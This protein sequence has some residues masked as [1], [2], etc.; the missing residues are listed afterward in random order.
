MMVTFVSQ[1]EKKALNKTRRVLDSFASRI[2]ENTWQ[3]IITHE[4]LNAVKKLLKKTASKNTAVSCHWLR[5]RSRSELIWIIGNRSKFNAQGIVP[6]HFTRKDI[7]NTRWENDWHYLPLIKCLAALASLFHDFGKASRYFQ[8]KLKPESKNKLGDPLRHEWVSVL[9][10]QAFVKNNS[11]VKNNS[12]AQWLDRLIHGDLNEM[13]LAQN[14]SET[15]L[16]NLPP[17]AG[18]L[19]WLIVSHHKLPINLNRNY[20]DD[21]LRTLDEALGQISQTWGYENRKD[22]KFYKAKL[23]QCL[24]FDDGLSSQSLP[25]LK[26]VKRWASKM[27]DCLF[28]LNK[29]MENGSWRL[30]LYHARLSLMLGDHNYS[31]Q[32]ASKT[33]HSDMDLIANTYRKDCNGHSKG[34]PNQKLDEHLVGVAHSALDIAQLLPAFENELPYAYDIRALKKKSPSAFGWQDKAVEKVKEWKQSVPVAYQDKQHGFFAVNMASTGCGKT[35]A[36]AKVMRALS[37]DCESLRFILALGLRTLTLQTGDEYR[38]RI[39]LDNSE[40][41]VMIGSRAVMELHKQ[42]KLEQK[43]QE[44]FNESAGAESMGALLDDDMI[45]YECVIPESR[46]NTVLIDER[47]RKFLYS[48]VLACTIDHL[49]PATECVRG[50]RYILPSLRLM[51]SDLV[52]DEIDDFNGAD[53]VA[54][55]RLIH[56]AG[57]LGRKVMIS[58]ATIP[59][60]LAEG[61]LN[62]YREGWLLFANTRDVSFNIACAWI[63]EFGTQIETLSDSDTKQALKC[64]ENYHQTF[65]KK[66][67]KKLKAEPIKRKVEI[68]SCQHI[69]EFRAQ[70]KTNEDKITIEHAYFNV[71]QKAI[72]E[73]H[74]QH[75]EIEP[76]TEKMVSIGLVRMANIDPCVALTEYLATT[77]W[78]NDI[79]FRVMAY[80]SQQVL[81]LRSE[82]EKHLDEVLKRNEKGGEIP[83]PFQNEIIRYH[84]SNSKSQHIIFIL[85]ATPVE[86]VGR[87]HDFDWAVVE[88]SSFRSIIQL[89]GRVLRHRNKIPKTPNIALMQYNLK[90]LINA[91]EHPAYCCPGYEQKDCLFS[92]HDINQLIDHKLLT[93]GINALPRIQRD[94]SLKYK[95]NFADMEHYSISKLLTG[96]KIKDSAALVGPEQMQ[97]WLTQCWWLTAYPQNYNRFRESG[98]DEQLFLEAE[99]GELKFMQ[100]TEGIPIEYVNRTAVYGIKVNQPVERILSKLWLDCDYQ[101]LIE[102]IANKTNKTKSQATRIYGEISLPV[103]SHKIQFYQYSYQ[104]GLSRLR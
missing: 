47:S 72:I 2:G 5:S 93:E 91:D 15:P 21:H 71:I 12:D 78:P 76:L 23:K 70:V 58:S 1:C 67:V 41:A 27:R 57:M 42:N 34:E 6:V 69:K 83:K 75:A 31:S 63:D 56:L 10:F 90:A 17:L 36:N 103:Y 35:Y 88:P 16:E 104:L 97:G 52:I 81:L 51:S 8:E 44:D 92:T 26:L 66:R 50:G 55:G 96:W 102:V 61:Y 60:D 22:E 74:L 98:L 39:G 14:I 9:L 54:I 7:V 19:A 100:K 79:D 77:D 80:H 46:L 99:C 73:K 45:D 85:V 82:Q 25:W 89:A 29:A 59:P 3:T 28:L 68:V 38:E 30:I 43:E 40:L 32:G 48:P 62:A 33:W 4:G 13:V 53:L 94:I 101:Q 11:E 49:I 65:I 18:L 20:K 64:Y 84:L 95:H 86:E 37:P 87:D 24:T